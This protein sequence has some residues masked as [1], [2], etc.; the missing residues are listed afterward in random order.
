MSEKDNAF[1]VT[2]QFPTLEGSSVWSPLLTTH[3]EPGCE[4]WR[5]VEGASLRQPSRTFSVLHAQPAQSALPLLFCPLAPLHPSLSSAPQASVQA[6][7]P[8]ATSSFLCS[9]SRCIVSDTEIVCSRLWILFT[10]LWPLYVQNAGVNNQSKESSHVALVFT[11]HVG[12][13]T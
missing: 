9:L 4:G 7:Y 3:L 5:Q 10:L 6:F 2:V 13:T 11:I 1:L 12:T 8:C